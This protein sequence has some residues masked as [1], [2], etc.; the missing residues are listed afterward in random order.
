MRT[1]CDGIVISYLFFYFLVGKSGVNGELSYI[2]M[3]R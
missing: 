3:Y 1:R 2:Q